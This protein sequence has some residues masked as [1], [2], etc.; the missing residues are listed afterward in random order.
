M[1]LIGFKDGYNKPGN[2][3]TIITR[4]KALYKIKEVSSML[5]KHGN[6]EIYMLYSYPQRFCEMDQKE[7]YQAVKR[8]GQKIF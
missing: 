4:Y 8:T 1:Y 5:L 2:S 7:F 6:D 3:G